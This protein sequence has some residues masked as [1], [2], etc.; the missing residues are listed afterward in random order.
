MEENK[1]DTV[2]RRDGRMEWICEHGVGHTYSAPE[3]LIKYG[4]IH[5]CDGCCHKSP[6]F[7]ELYIESRGRE[8]E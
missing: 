6:R 1:K 7:K 2:I 5:S 3:R 8:N 4:Y